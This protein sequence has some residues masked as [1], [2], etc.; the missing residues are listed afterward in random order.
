[1]TREL[2]PV[3]LLASEHARREK[4][5]FNFRL[6]VLEPE[7]AVRKGFASITNPIHIVSEKR[8]LESIES[9]LYP[10]AGCWIRVDK[11]RVE[12][13]RPRESIKVERKGHD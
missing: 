10:H 11:N 8:I 3:E 1:M 5:S 6:P 2:L 7:E 13:A 12:A 9:A 4:D